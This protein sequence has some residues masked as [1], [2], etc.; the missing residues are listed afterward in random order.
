ML[1]GN[2]WGVFL[3]AALVLNLAPG[4]DLVYLLSRSLGQGRRIGIASSLGVC[5]GALVHVAA[6]AMGLS[7]LLAQSAPAFMLVKWLGA[8][9]LVY[10]GL[11]A[12]RRGASPGVEPASPAPGAAD[13]SVWQAFRQGVL[14]DVFNPKV[15]LFFMAFL[16]Q[17]T[18]PEAGALGLQ[19]LTLGTIVVLVGLAVEIPLV[20][21]A[22]TLRRRFARYRGTAIGL[23]RL[24]GVMLVGLGVRLALSE[25]PR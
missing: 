17:F 5:S 12:L 20:L 15:A 21:A 23:H 19:L 4:P 16:P 7:V 2:D 22:D 13:G 9:Y 14:I 1:A 11:T 25:M 3:L 18:H 24:M 8:A 6:A 10:L